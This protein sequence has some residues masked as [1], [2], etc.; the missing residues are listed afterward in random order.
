[1]RLEA[2][3]DAAEG[4][5]EAEDPEWRAEA[6]SGEEQSKLVVIVPHCDGRKVV[7]RSVVRSGVCGVGMSAS[8]S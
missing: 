1:M 6:G 3:A 7:M 4:R 2:G 8:A 5:A